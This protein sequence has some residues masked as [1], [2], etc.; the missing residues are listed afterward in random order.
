MGDHAPNEVGFGQR[1]FLGVGHACL[2][3]PA[4]FGFVLAPHIVAGS[5]AIAKAHER[6]CFLGVAGDDVR[7]DREFASLML[8]NTDAH[9]PILGKGMTS[10]L[11]L[12]SERCQRVFRCIELSWRIGDEQ[13]D[14][15]LA[16]A[17]GH[18]GA[19][20]VLDVKP[21][22]LRVNQV[23]QRVRG[24]RCIRIVGAIGRWQR[25]VGPD[26]HAIML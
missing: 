4:F 21:I 22:V 11:P 16:A 19:A 20:D 15:S 24:S 6:H 25:P 9:R 12:K 1:V 26:F 7:V 10:L 2:E 5:E 13:I 23:D 8:D 3:D 14:V 18:R 17:S